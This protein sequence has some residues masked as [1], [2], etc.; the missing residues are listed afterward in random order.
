MPKTREATEIL[1]RA[2]KALRSGESG[3]VTVLESGEVQQP[4]PVLKPG[5]KLH[6]WFVPVTVGDLLAGF[7]EFQPDAT[8]MRY[9][10][11]QRHEGSLEGC[12]T[13]ESWIDE[14]AIRRRVENNARPGEKAREQFFT[15]DR[16]P[17]RLSWAVL[18]ES[19]DGTTRTVH[20]AGNMMWD[21]PSGDTGSFGRGSPC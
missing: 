16:A 17:S 9:S 1:K 11:F 18:L 4:I 6:S 13:A 5:G 12:P 21:A 3:G 19:P 2:R 7:F 15:Y 8:L 14:T 10:S 20:V